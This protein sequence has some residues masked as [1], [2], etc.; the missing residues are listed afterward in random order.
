[1]FKPNWRLLGA[2][3]YLWADIAVLEVCFIAAGH[4]P[5]LAVVVLAY[6]IGYLSNT[7]PVPG[8]IGVLDGSL[9]GMF[10][11]FHV[12]AS[13]ATAATVVYHAIALWIP[14]TWG[15][16]AFIV[17]RRTK[18]QPLKLRPARRA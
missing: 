13:L 9:V 12:N 3:A 5:P 17:L 10:V 15:T 7:L 8:S 11:L 4:A 2:F 6:Q 18:N 16:I 1:M 14:A